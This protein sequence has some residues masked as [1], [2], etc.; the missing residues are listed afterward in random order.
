MATQLNVEGQGWSITFGTS[1][2]AANLIKI[3]LPDETRGEI[4][5]THQGSTV[6]T[7]DPA[8]VIDPGESSIEFEWDPEQPDLV[9]ASAETIT[10]TAPLMTG[11]ATAGYYEAD[12]FVKSQKHGDIDNGAKIVTTITVRW[13]ER[14]TWTDAVDS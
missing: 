7:T 5:R 11:Q 8:T 13:R 12:G 9:G 10:I 6:M 2:Y 3:S 14:L 4:D 1:S